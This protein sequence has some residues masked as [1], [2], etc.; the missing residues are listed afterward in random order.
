VIALFSV[1]AFVLSVGAVRAFLEVS[2][3]RLV[4]R[5]G[6]RSSHERPTPT[7]GG[8][9]AIVVFLAVA[10]VA[11]A[12]D[13]VSGGPRWWAAALC[14]GTLGLLGL[15]DDAFDLPRSARYATH[16]LVAT[17]IVH[18]VG[19]PGPRFGLGGAAA[20]VAAVVFV[21]GLINAFNFMDGI[22]ALVGSTGVLIVG[23]L[24]W[25][26]HDPI[27]ILLAACYCGFLVFNLPPA[28]IFMGDAGST[29]LGGLVGVAVLSGRAALEPRH[30]LI[31]APLIGDSAYTVVRRLLRRENILK[32]HHSH[33][34][35][36]LLRAGHS[37]AR[38]SGSYAAATLALGAWAVWA[39]NGAAW[40]GVLGC[41]ALAIAL[42]IYLSRRGVPFRRP[43][44]RSEPTGSVPRPSGSGQD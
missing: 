41:I 25:V 31:F 34:Y 4:D 10:A 9:P 30:F 44:R 11:V 26:T 16:V 7:G 32:A 37:H 39:G 36:R 23:F 17:A 27:W 8:F 33:M 3:R 13:V 14:A 12:L 6:A 18:W 43:T 35:Q 5:P 28:R 38:I 22:D 24:A 20:S 15:V 2:R 42:E 19:H 21:T 1:A 29:A 40:V